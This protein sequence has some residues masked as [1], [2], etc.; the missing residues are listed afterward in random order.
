MFNVHVVEPIQRI[1][2]S[3]LCACLAYEFSFTFYLHLDSSSGKSRDIWISM[4]E[5]ECSSKRS[6]VSVFFPTLRRPYSLCVIGSNWNR[7]KFMIK[8]GSST[9]QWQSLTDW[10]TFAHSN[11]TIW[12]HCMHKHIHF[13]SIQRFNCVRLRVDNSDKT[14]YCQLN[15]KSER[16]DIEWIKKKLIAAQYMCAPHTQYSPRIPACPQRNRCE[17]SKVKVSRNFFRWLFPLSLHSD[18]LEMVKRRRW[19][20]KSQHESLNANRKSINGWKFSIRISAITLFCMSVQQFVVHFGRYELGESFCVY[21]HSHI[22]YT[23]TQYVMAEV[24]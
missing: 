13:I 11:F 9:S 16:E 20:K 10:K 2:L 24:Q 18:W 14:N 21:S 12:F 3:K 19:S 15:R 6:I 1:V 5:N 22:Y 17:E 23:H 7:N 8:C 4:H